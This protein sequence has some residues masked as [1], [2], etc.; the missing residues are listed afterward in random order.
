M[1]IPASALLIVIWPAF[2]WLDYYVGFADYLKKSFRCVR[3]DHSMIVF[4]LFA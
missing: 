4:D 1:G 2:W 3:S